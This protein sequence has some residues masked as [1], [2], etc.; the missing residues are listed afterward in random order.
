MIVVWST[1][2]ELAES[3]RGRAVCAIVDPAKLAAI[4]AE[5]I[6]LRGVLDLS[7][8]E[9]ADVL[10][11][12]VCAHGEQIMIARRLPDMH[13]I[14]GPLLNMPQARAFALALLDAPAA[15]AQDIERMIGE[16]TQ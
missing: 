14:G 5:L 4:I 9:I 11:V 7:E 15:T 3:E 10:E 1:N 12:R 6:R 13:K 8:S 16:V 2:S